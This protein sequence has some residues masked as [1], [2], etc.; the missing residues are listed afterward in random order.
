MFVPR[1]RK[2]DFTSDIYST[3]GQFRY[4]LDKAEIWLGGRYESHSDYSDEFSGS[5][6]VQA[7]FAESGHVKV[8]YGSA[9]RTPYSRQLFEDSSLDQEK[10]STLSAQLAWHPDSRQNYELTLFHSRL[11]DHRSEDPYGGLSLGS[12]LEMYGAELS[13]HF[14]LTETLTAHAGLSW[15]DGGNGKDDFSVL[16]FTVMPPNGPPEDFYYNWSQDYDQGPGMVGAFQS[17]LGHRHRSQ[18]TRDSLCRWRQGR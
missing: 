17:R 11:K 13:L 10:I 9:F 3:F 5:M 1:I 4:R 7:P 8:T 18:S 15:V 2:Q 14:P 16:A 6:G 12:D